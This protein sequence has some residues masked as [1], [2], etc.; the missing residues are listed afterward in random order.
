MPETKESSS[1]A[2]VEKERWERETL[3]PGLAK[4]PERKKS[5]QTVSL[6]RGRTDSIP[7]LT[8]EDVDFE[9]RHL[10]SR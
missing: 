1:P 7:R 2:E 8:L 9:Q 6:E 4:H 3:E 5:F 10:V